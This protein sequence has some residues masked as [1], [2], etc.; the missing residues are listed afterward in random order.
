MSWQA[1]FYFFHKSQT[2]HISI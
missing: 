1:I 2:H